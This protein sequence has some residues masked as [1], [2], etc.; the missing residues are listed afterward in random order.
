MYNVNFIIPEKG[1]KKELVNLASNNAKEYFD[2]EIKLIDNKNRRTIDVNNELGK[3]L[4][5]NVE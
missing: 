3:L 2:R 4:N 1:K 5:I